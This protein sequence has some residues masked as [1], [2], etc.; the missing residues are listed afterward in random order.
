VCLNFLNHFIEQGLLVRIKLRSKFVLSAK[1]NER[2]NFGVIKVEVALDH[3]VIE[4]FEALDDN[5]FKGAI[6]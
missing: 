6:V 2:Q 5:P 1:E 4:I 3:F